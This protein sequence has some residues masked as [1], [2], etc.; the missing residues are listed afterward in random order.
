MNRREFLKKSLIGGGVATLSVNPSVAKLVKE[1][2]ARLSQAES[3]SEAYVTEPARRIGVLT[4][5]DVLVVG[6]G[7]AGVA[8]AVCAAR[9]GA[10]TVL[11][12]RY[13]HLGGLWTGGLVLPT[14]STHG[15]GRAGR[16]ERAIEGI[17]S[18]ILQRL[19]GL[20]AT[21]G[22]VNP[23][24]DPEA[25]KYVLDCLCEEAHV[26]VIYHCVATQAIID[27]DVIKGV[28]IESKSGRQA[29]MCKAV[30]DCT[31]DGDVFYWAGEAF[32]EIHYRIGYVG[33]VGG[34][35]QINREAEGFRNVSLGGPTPTQA[36]IRWYSLPWSTHPKEDGLDVR[37][38]SRLQRECRKEIW[39][40]VEKAKRVPGYEKIFLLDTAPQL[41]V[42]A[43]RMLK[44]RYCLTLDDSMRYKTFKDCIGMSGAWTSLP[45]KGKTIESKDRP[46]WQ[47]PYRALLPEKTKNLIV[48]GR[49]F[50]FDRG[51][52]EDAREVGTCL[53]TGQA[54]GTAAAMAVAQRTSMDEVD[55]AKLQSRLKAQNV[56][57]TI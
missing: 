15:L 17:C 23:V 54:A 51:L 56:R 49:C 16:Q 26:E 36:G 25:G 31:G 20:H 27:S 55:I 44:G 38:L 29:V 45:Y 13:N 39:Q 18:E 9:E 21:L 34:C 19:D 50:S 32:D 46:V 7:P 8:A 42:R 47:I 37:N 3:S 2:D 14:N 6:G 22:E 30:V 12:E 5:C 33:R 57:L 4:S 28:F 1:T 35:D 10:K 24:I 53:V 41:G 11:L 48:S 40:Y 43:T 52:L